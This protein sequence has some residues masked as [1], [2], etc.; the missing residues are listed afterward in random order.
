MVLILQ[1]YCIVG[2][3][4]SIGAICTFLMSTVDEAKSF[5]QRKSA[6]AS[7]QGLSPKPSELEASLPEL[8][9]GFLLAVSTLPFRTLVVEIF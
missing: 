5:I 6:A 8:Q 2:N 4:V 7:L 1:Q 3:F 9:R